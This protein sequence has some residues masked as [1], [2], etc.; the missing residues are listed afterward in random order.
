MDGLSLLF[1]TSDFRPRWECG[2]WTSAHGWLHILA[3]L[4][5]WSAYI[6]IPAVLGYFL[7]RRKDLPFRMIFLLFCAFILACGTTHLMEA[8]M[9]WWPAYRLAAAIKV[10]TAVVSWATVIALAPATPKALALRTPTELEA[11][12]RKRQRAEESL[13][14]S[15]ERFR[16]LVEGTTDYAMY[17]LDP[18]GF[19]VSWNAGA[20]RIIGYKAEEIIGKPFTR[21]FTE[22]DLC[23]QEPQNE[24]AA[25][26]AAGRLEVEN[27][28]VRKDGSK[29]WNH[30][31]LTAMRDPAG[32]LQ[33]FW[34][35]TH[36]L[37]ERKRAEERFRGLLESAPDA[38]VIVQADGTIALVN[39]Q[40]EQ[41]FGYPRQEL[42]G[43]QVEM[44]IP[45]RYRQRHSGY[46][47]SYFE[48]PT[49]RPMGAN[50]SLF[51]RRKDG[52]EFPVEISLSPLVTEE[53]IL[54]S[55]AIRDVTG[56]KQIE[57]N[58]RASEE[59]FRALTQSVNDAV[60]SADTSG[61]IVFWNKGAQVI[62]GYAE[63]E[64]VGQPLTLLMPEPYHEAYRE[65]LKRFQ[66]TGDSR[67]IGKLIE[68]Q[69][70]RK[71]GSEFPLE[72][73]L[74][75]WET[76]QGKFF[77]GVLRDI[78]LRKQAED[79]LEKS[80]RFVAR[81]A[82]MM[83]SILFV[84]DLKEQHYLF[85]NQRVE[86]ILGYAGEETKL[87][88]M[89]VLLDKIHPDDLGK[90]EWANEQYQTADDGAVI[91]TEYR[92][93]HADGHWRW[94]HNRN[95]VFVRDSEGNP[96]QIL[97]T[98][99]DITE[100]KRLE[101]EV[102]EIAASE[103]RRFG[104][105][106]HDGM[107]QELAGLGMLADNLADV[108]RESSPNEALRAHRIAQGLQHALGEVR[109]LARGLIP[110]D[111]DAEGLMAALTELTTSISALH[112]IRCVFD[113]R[114]PVPVDDVYTAT[115]LFRIAQE[116][117][118]NAFKHGQARTIRVSLEAKEFYIM[119]KIADDGIGLPVTE[120][121]KEG[122]GLR[123][124]RYRAGQIGASLGVYPGPN[125]GTVVTCT[126]FRGAF[127]E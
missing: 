126:L 97:G 39:R 76:G 71:D 62:F 35:I 124:M 86:S 69:G 116:A 105:E 63:E 25:A 47:N 30:S 15:E 24:L 77:S 46:R 64:V 32:N 118:T 16:M 84:Y 28:R 98:A 87:P 57:Q 93:R 21:F 115:Q 80:R 23:R 89:P 19:V 4:G 43:Q 20:E 51:G 73:S 53:G 112:G 33:G 95:K 18:D 125:R 108:L 102:L 121:R 109:A 122:M 29:Y 101:Q 96:W 79:A 120:T 54:V 113:C 13:R 48:H 119:L 45:E 2:S 106:L 65:G 100:R 94:F 11:Q 99:Q 81:I 117:I 1:D 110:V 52:H 42:L 88:G 83:P 91:E 22:E 50:L 61:R 104:Q 82:E 7:L 75:V 6:A 8:T 10:L 92:M 14:L 114:E 3:D 44:L 26:A 27:W 34:K 55:S 60:I 59:R 41:L 85:V 9:F 12:I 67:V 123:I 127:N 37:T 103:Q 74:A 70:R 49:A 78:T 56:R 5:V 66:A 111:V 31:I 107:G 17:M 68:L 40:T 38:I 58:L 36:D 90:V 72:L